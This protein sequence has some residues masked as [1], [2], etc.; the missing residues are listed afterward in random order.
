MIYNAATFEEQ[1][2]LEHPERVFQIQVNKLGNLLVSYGYATTRLWD[3]TSGECLKVVDNPPKKP[4]PHTIKF[5]NKDS[6]VLVGGVDRVFRYFSIHDHCTQW[7]VKTKIDEKILEG[8]VLNL[9]TCTCL[10]PDG[11]MVVFVYRKHPVTLWD[12]VI[13]M[14]LGQYSIPLGETD[15]TTHATTYGEVV[16]LAWYVLASFHVDVKRILT[17]F[18]CY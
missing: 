18:L 2:V 14:L 9:P 10:S 4:R 1:R 12:L 17:F 3:T 8:S 15:M 6:A 7:T 11:N 13:D 5:V 16:S